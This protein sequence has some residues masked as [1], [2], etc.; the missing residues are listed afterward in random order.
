MSGKSRWIKI[1]VVSLVI[2]A[3]LGGGITA[4]KTLFAP[5]A[6]RLLSK[7]EATYAKGLDAL[8]GGDAAGAAARF[9]EANLQASKALD[10]VAKEKQKASKGEGDAT[11]DL[12]QLEGQA[13]WLKCRALRDTFF[14]KAI[15]EGHPLPEATDSIGGG[16]FRSVLSIPDNQAR[17]EA[18]LCLRESARRLTGDA[19]VQR[20]ALL[21]ELML[22]ALDWNVIEKTA[23]QVLQIDAKDPWALYLLARFDFEQ[24]TIDG[25][26]LAAAKGKRSRE[27]IQQ[28]RLH[29]K[30][31][32][33]T[34]NYPL[35]RTLYLEAEIAQWLR[36]DAAKSGGARREVEEATLRS[37]LFGGKGAL[38]RARAGE[39]L[40]H[41]SKWDAEGVIGLHELALDLA[42]EDSRQPGA[43]PEQVIELLNETLA[44]CQKLAD[45]DPTRVPECALSVLQALSKAQPVLVLEPPPDWKKDLDVAQGLMRKAR[46]QKVSNPTLYEA[47]AGLLAREAH[48]EGKRGHRDRRAELN[49]QA[50]QWVEDGLRLGAEAKLPPLQLVGLNTLAAEMK[51]LNGDKPEQL[52]ANLNALTEAKTPRA[53]TLVALL[54]AAAAERDGRLAD[55]RKLLEKV[56]VSDEADLALR[57]H[58]VLGGVYLALG[59]P[60]KALV[61]LQQVQRAYAVFDKLSPQEKAWALEFVR[62]PEDL[63]LQMVTA[64]ADS[65]LA[66]IRAFVQRNPGKPASLDLIAHHDKAIAELRKQFQKK[67]PQDRQA[68]QILVAYY[69]A[70]RRDDE[71]ENEMTELRG[72]Y[73]D[74]VDVLRTDVTLTMAGRDAVG[75][76]RDRAALLKE[77][78][79]RIDQFIKDHPSD[80]D[81]RFFRVEWLIGSKR[82]DDALTYLQSPTNFADTKSERYQRVLATALLT[83]GDREGS[84]KVLEHL[85]HDSATDALLIQ[86]ASASEQDKLVQQAVARHE[87]NALFQSWQAM[88]AFNKRDYEAAAEA[89]LRTS[90]FNRYAA[91][92]KRGL[93]Q[94]LLALAQ[95]DP[96]KSR[97]LAAR[98]LKA[99]P[100]EPLLLLA[101]AYASM[102][103]DDIGAPG[104]DPDPV[105]SMASALNAWE[106]KILEQQPQMKATAPLTKAG[107]WAMA[108]RQD[109]ALT[110]AVRALNMDPKNPAALQLTIALALELR[111]PDLRTQTRKRL[112]TL[113]QVQPDDVAVR[114]LEARFDEANEQ[115]KDAVAIYEDLLKKDA[116]LAAAYPGLILLL[117]KQGDKERANDYAKRWRKELPD[118]IPAAQMEVRLR[119]ESNEAAEGRKLAETF[120]DEQ[121]TKERKRLESDKPAAGV[122]AKKAE[123]ARQVLLDQAR[124]NLQ[125]Q[126]ILGLMQGKAWSASE[127]WLN[128]ILAKHPDHL[129]ALVLLGDLYVSQSS[130]EKARQA[131]EKVLAQDKTNAGAGNNLAWMLAKYFNNAPEALRMAQ[132]LRKGRFS[133]KPIS[134]DRLRP[135]FLDTL[136]VIY[137]KMDKG[138]LAS[139][140]RDLFE[141]ARQRYPH[142]PRLY[143]YLGHAYV[144]LLETDRAERLYATALEVAGK[145]G[146][147]FLSPEKCQEVIDEV[148][149]AQKKLKE[150]AK[151]R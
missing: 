138:S 77:A 79:R 8:K 42:V 100:D 66:K 102:R 110:E 132:E 103:L 71:A 49:K 92:G 109:L 58:M 2:G 16:T 105:K 67:T 83:K 111:D 143:M 75:K 126:M 37:L 9:E 68:R 144:G 55:A 3:L 91:T 45:K 120:I 107:F 18:F 28:A 86:A 38:A 17:Q 125:L 128:E 129:A 20:Q 24:P 30:Q 151:L 33:D 7:G 140:M 32:K 39:G 1:T 131:Y 11:V 122:D 70:T 62:S 84:Q 93:L 116:K 46:E 142:D 29:I 23:R 25:R 36:E 85:P 104:D 61:S 6:Q 123:K 54:E 145:S 95:A 64:H 134:G 99:T 34:N 4:S 78:D 81:A 112:D 101:C 69:S 127:S 108:G 87:G 15:V 149:A 136:G 52:R 10:A 50:L 98:M 12:P 35:W 146:Q 119:A 97:N 51:T 73:P 41:P 57:A 113:K 147:Q 56:L 117:D 88:L 94:S 118:S 26:S 141:E 22:P 59:E 115:P 63:A 44:L 139:E 150:T 74:S 43:T 14:A 65:A 106:Q 121:M 96:A 27:R 53:R 137:T 80:L 21:T 60:D 82:V 89:F 133:H 148:H 130:W 47:I 72:Y 19:E 5:G 40:E 90:R 114:L 135:E 13:L 31:L 76:P 124:L 48:I